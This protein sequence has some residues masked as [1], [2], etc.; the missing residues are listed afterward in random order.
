[1]NKDKVSAIIEKVIFYLAVI[2]A[3]FQ[4]NN[5]IFP[6]IDPIPLQNMHL[7]F[8]FVL[9]FLVAIKKEL[10]N[11]KS[12]YRIL[13]STA[14]LILAMIAT[15]YI[16]F[17][18]KEM[19]QSV[20]QATK[21]DLLI[22]VILLIV[23]LEATHVTFGKA[24]PILIVI[25]IVY[26]ITGPYFS[27]I[28]YHGGFS[29]KRIISTLVTNFS[30][31]YGSLLMTSATYIALFM[32]FGGLLTT[33][34]AGQFF[35]DIAM[36]IG[37]K[38]RAGA[39]LAAIIASA[40]MGMINGSAVAVVATTGVLTIPLMMKRGYKP[41]FASAISSVASTGG[42][43]LPP[44]MG[45]GAFIM[46]ELTGNTYA[47]VAYCA[48]VP[49]I[50]YYTLCASV[51]IVRVNK[52]GIEPLPPEDIPD[53]KKTIREGILYIVPIIGL[54]YALSSGYST[55]RA[56]LISIALL[57]LVK[58][59]KIIVSEPRK[60][61]ELNNYK[62]IV[63]GLAEGGKSCIGIAV[64]MASVGV[65]SNTLISTGLANRLISMILQMGSE[66]A[67]FSLCITAVLTLILGCGVPTTAAYIVMAMMAAPT[68]IKIGLP[69]LGV[70][71]FIFYFAAVA[72]LT[73]PVAPATIVAARIAN[74][75][76]VK[77][78]G[79]GMKMCISA[80]VL[81]F[82]F[83]FREEMLLQGNLFDII[84]VVGSAFVGLVALSFFME[85]YIFAKNTILQ[86]IVLA[87]SSVLLILPLQL[88]YTITALVLVLVIII[89]QRRTMKAL[90]K[91]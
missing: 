3:L 12:K 16:Q 78:C 63:E 37:G 77:A 45:V 28:F 48:I 88:K 52:M 84:N 62:S 32:I 58:I 19:V 50:L 47:R 13:W 44:V 8:S 42:M 82:I 54:I 70:H 49:A 10:L 56:A 60:I 76:Y 31:L 17:N 2:M 69:V 64:T 67:F 90:L 29:Y 4:L 21:I 80:F 55:S 26:M 34:G 9:I 66:G 41:D 33:T 24:I 59:L 71:L 86:Q 89:W 57:I 15:L 5:S 40:L 75:N 39:G 85:R 46:A 18:Y 14:I 74:S 72:N 20:G 22:G 65:L 25:G 61:L 87:I 79:Q 27:G 7:M 11:D 38:Y 36:V 68:L 35:V 6:G 1:M 43:I 30:G 53:P 81:P 73:P 83:V 91:G 51:V 23:T